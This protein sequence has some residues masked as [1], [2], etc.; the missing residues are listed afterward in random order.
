[1]AGTDLRPDL[2]LCNVVN[3]FADD[4]G[5]GMKVVSTLRKVH[6]R[7]LE[8]LHRIE[9]QGA[10]TEVVYMALRTGAELVRS[11]RDDPLFELTAADEGAVMERILDEYSVFL[12]LRGETGAEAASVVDD[13]RR[14]GLADGARV[15]AMLDA[16]ES[17]VSLDEDEARHG[18][19]RD[20]L[21]QR[22]RRAR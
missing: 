14:A 5:R 1:M 18:R 10:D 2:V 16:Y 3:A 12:T 9:T 6:D 7:G 17:A 19:V 21:L 11:L 15:Q 4:V 13:L 20:A 22:V 8:F